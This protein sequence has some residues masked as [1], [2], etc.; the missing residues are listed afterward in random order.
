MLSA[1]AADL[2]ALPGTQVQVITD[3]HRLPGPLPDCELVH[4]HTSDEEQSALCR[5]AAQADWTIIIAPEFDDMLHQRCRWVE[6]SSGRLLSPSSDLVALL[7]DKHA[8]TQHLQR[9]GIR[10][11]HGY[12]WRPG[13][14]SPT[15]LPCPMVIKPNDGAGS[16]DTF[17]CRDASQRDDTLATFHQPARLESFVDGLAASV[18]FLCG[19]TGCFA[20]PACSQR[21]RID[22]RISYIGGALPLANA[23]N[24][25]ATTIARRA[26]E[27]LQ[28]PRGFIGV[29]LVLG[30]NS[31]GSADHIIEINPRL[32]TSYVGLRIA[33]RANLGQ[34]MLDVAAGNPPD[35]S[36]DETPLEFNADGTVRRASVDNNHRF[37]P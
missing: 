20:L 8:T 25:R 33:A 31:D 35:L 18:A 23:L 17:I 10:T 26:I 12:L 16:Q 22:S 4:V 6:A 19:P 15:P 2:A 21:L 7:S 24:K 1:L 13:D 30:N 36:F 37:V 32:T 28:Q 5:L 3:P 34:A 14:P 29:D 9:H 27:T 11:P